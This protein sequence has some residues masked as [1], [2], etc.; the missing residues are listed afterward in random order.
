MPNFAVSAL[1]VCAGA[2][3]GSLLR[4]LANIFLN[5]LM[6]AFPLGTLAVNLTGS[7]IMGAALS[8]FDSHSVTGDLKLAV[9]TGFLGSLT[10]FSAFAA[11]M[12]AL[13]QSGRYLVCAIALGLHVFGSIAMIFAGFALFQAFARA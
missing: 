9:I 6:A 5:P 2:C 3:A 4:W 11:E 8:F 10:T 7:L 12:A 1:A 13:L